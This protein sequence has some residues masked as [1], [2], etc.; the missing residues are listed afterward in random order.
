MPFDLSQVE[1]N[2]NEKYWIDEYGSNNLVW[3]APRSLDQPKSYNLYLGIFDARDINRICNESGLADT[4]EMRRIENLER[5]AQQTCFAR[6]R[7]DKDQKVDLEKFSVSTLPWALGRLAAGK[8]DDLTA[9]NFASAKQSLQLEIHDFFS[10]LKQAS[11]QGKE[12][13]QTDGLARPLSGADV[14]RL[15]E[16][17]FNWAGFWPEKKRLGLVE[18]YLLKR[19]KE[20]EK[21]S[22]VEPSPRVDESEEKLTAFLKDQGTELVAVFDGLD[23]LTKPEQFLVRCGARLARD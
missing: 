7:I 13:E 22:Q 3:L 4:D 1:N 17:L 11:S 16:L 8:L 23:R 20:R 19:S 18:V 14:V 15:A 9:D 6:F 5:G 10:G 12:E 2:S 21:S